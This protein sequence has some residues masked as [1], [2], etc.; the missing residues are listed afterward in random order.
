[1]NLLEQIKQLAFTYGINAK[2]EQFFVNN[3]E[4]VQV[5]L[6]S[7]RLPDFQVM[8]ALKPSGATAQPTGLGVFTV[9]RPLKVS[10]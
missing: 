6:P 10:K 5:I 9:Q 7:K 3:A 2:F 1:M 4:A 8:A